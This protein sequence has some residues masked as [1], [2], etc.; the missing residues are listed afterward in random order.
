MKTRFSLRRQGLA[1]LALL[2]FAAGPARAQSV[3]VGTTAPDASAAL[4]VVSS[5]KGALLPRLTQAQRGGIAA[6]ATGLLVFQTDGAQPGFWYNAGPAATPAWT[7][8][9]PTGVGDNLGSHTAATNLALGANALVGTGASVGAAVGV[10]VRADGGLNL[11]QNTYGNNLFLGYQS[12]FAN[13]TGFSNLFSGT[14]SGFNNTTGNNNVFLGNNS[15]QANTTGTDNLFSGV[16]SGFNN[17]TGG[18]NLFLGTF[19]G[20]ANTGGEGNLFLG[21]ES[22][23]SN[24][25]GRFN[26]FLGIQSGWGNT[27]GNNNLFL[28]T[29]TGS[30]NTTGSDNLF[31]GVNSGLSNT[32]GERNL[33]SGT[34]SGFNNTTGEHNLF[35]GHQSGENNTTGSS[36]TALG[37]NSGPA[38]GSGALTNATALGANVVLTRSNT[39]VLGTGASV[40][41]GT[42]APAAR[43]HVYAADN[44]AVVRIQSSG[45]FGSAG[46][47]LWSDPQGAASEWRPAFLRST[48]AGGFTGGL[49][50]YTNGSGA[51]N[52]T[53]A[54]EGMRLVN[55]RLG[56]GTATP[57]F[58]LDVNGSIRCVGA[59]NTTS[60]QRLKQHIRPLAGAL[61]GVGRLRGVRY[62]FRQSE[63][64]AL[65][66]PAGEQLG[67]LAQE[68][69]RVYPELVS[70]DAQGYKAINYAQ[71]APVL[72]EA[73]KELK[74]ENDLLQTR[75]AALETQV[76]ADHADLQTLQHQ[77]ARL[78]G[79]AAPVPGAQAQA[80]R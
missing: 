33:F 70:T 37:Y 15:G 1:L 18:R 54:V 76:A 45:G 67:L 7:F 20:F 8:L 52:L 64:P 11:G 27:T 22:G 5:G 13:T 60:D 32:A 63:F 44:P 36:N 42:P 57:A 12:G 69:E 62:A 38:S 61:A 16:A 3:G 51:A 46:L 58:T 43:L 59:V 55:G 41:I 34:F 14:F 9:S 53:G 74:A 35:L 4:D 29:A 79:E 21:Y 49:A 40:G 2:A 73:L 50:F 24:G 72:I 10:G 77:L 75:H 56:I 65:Q 78:L 17:T 26:L 39:V 68:V 25:T 31:L 66:L 28:G 23:Y 80:R 30:F 6:P 71:L 19:S 47:E 48:D